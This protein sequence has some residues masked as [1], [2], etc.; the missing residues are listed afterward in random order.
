MTACPCGADAP[1]ATHCEPLLDGEAAATAE[2]LMRSRYTAYELLQRGDSRAA[3]HLWRTW[4][5]RTRPERVEPS[6]GLRWTGLSVTATVGGAQD[7]LDGRVHFRASWETGEGDTY[8]SGAHA[9]ASSFVR[10][11]GRWVYVSGDDLP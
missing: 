7:D 11:G 9:E 3:D 5:P 4:H 10:R 6:P 2:A 1:F 8:Q